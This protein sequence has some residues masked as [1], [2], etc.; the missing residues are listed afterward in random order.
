MARS[1]QTARSR[2]NWRYPAAGNSAAGGIAADKKSGM[3]CGVA[4]SGENAASNAPCAWRSS[5]AKH[6]EITAGAS[7]WRSSINAAS[8]EKAAKRAG[9]AA[10]AKTGAG[11]SSVSK[12]KPARL[13]SGIRKAAEGGKAEWRLRVTA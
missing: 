4:A 7:N 11:N 3:K 12:K 2:E 5:V 10:L 8:R 9:L 13:V 1:E 6:R